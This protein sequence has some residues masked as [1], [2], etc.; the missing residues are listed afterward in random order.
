MSWELLYINLMQLH[1]QAWPL[2]PLSN[3]KLTSHPKQSVSV[4]MQAKSF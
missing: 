2:I 4:P 3:L 1:K